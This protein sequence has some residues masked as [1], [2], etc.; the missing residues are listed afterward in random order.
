MFN[1]KLTYRAAAFLIAFTATSPITALAKKEP[2][3]ESKQDIG[4]GMVAHARKYLGVNYN[5][6]GRASKN[7]PGLDCLGLIFRAIQDQF[8]IPWMIWSTKPST[9]MPQLNASK[10]DHKTVFLRDENVAQVVDGLNEGDVIFFLE[11]VSPSMAKTYEKDTKDKLIWRDGV[12]YRVEHVA[13]Y[14]GSK[15]LGS[16]GNEPVIAQAH[17]LSGDIVKESATQY[18]RWH[19]FDAVAIISYDF[20]APKGKPTAVA[21]K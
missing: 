5:W 10:R 11:K 17:I 19:V 15:Y 16:Q 6:E 7:H 13:I 20:L 21:M 14:T 3:V 4:A 9:L 18:I 1:H 12:P 8:G 2:V